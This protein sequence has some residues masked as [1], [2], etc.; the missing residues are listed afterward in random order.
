M[1]R[2]IYQLVAI[3][4]N[5]NEYVIE[6][7]NDNKN[8]KGK[9]S[10]LDRGISRF[11][12]SQHLASHLYESGK[13]P[14]VPVRF[15]I[16]YN[17]DGIKEIPLIFYDE[18]LNSICKNVDNEAVM[19][20]YALKYYLRLE[21]ALKN[22]GFYNYLMFMNEKNVS[23]KK[24]GNI[25]HNRLIANISR[26]YKN[27]VLLEN[28]NSEKVEIQYDIMKDLMNY[29]QLRTLHYFYKSYTNRNLKEV[30]EA[31]ESVKHETTF[32]SLLER[33]SKKVSEVPE[34]LQKAY[35]QGGMD[36]VYALVDGDEVIEKGYK[37]R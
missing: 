37:F 5:N 13:L 32:E 18:E 2:E 4:Q 6:L 25:L 20:D 33:E 7:T 35:E 28:P 29:K 8:N 36:D 14:N 22:D 30:E 19:S 24:S 9:L 34:H 21:E 31:N 27:F 17:Y 15:V 23:N 16:R 11:S 3:D 1:V 12:N 10:F 26:F